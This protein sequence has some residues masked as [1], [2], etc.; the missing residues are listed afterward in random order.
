MTTVTNN[1][2]VLDTLGLSQANTTTKDKYSELGADAF[3]ELMIAQIQNQNPLEPMENGDFIAQLAQ[4]SSTSG[5]QDLN[6]SFAG[7]ASSLQSYQ[8]LQASSLIGR[9]VLV[10]SDTGSLQS[11]DTL[12][13]RVALESST[14]QLVIEIEDMSGQVVRQIN[15][16]SQRAGVAEFSWDGL[17]DSGQAMSPGTYRV[18]ANAMI[19]GKPT[20]MDTA[21]YLPV[22][23]VNLMSNSRDIQLNMS[24]IGSVGMSQVIQVR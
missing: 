24:G 8:A 11:D 20:A 6:D 14:T 21:I 7:L 16:G 1:T 10:A 15:L 2:A 17:N 22:E 12:D 23:S 9:E 5:I 13:G 4:F 18:R 3:L 19:E